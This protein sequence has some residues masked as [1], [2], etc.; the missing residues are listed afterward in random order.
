MSAEEEGY[1]DVADD[2]GASQQQHLQEGEQ[3]TA[4]ALAALAAVQRP[5]KQFVERAPP[6]RSASVTKSQ[7]LFAEIRAQME[8]GPG[9]SLEACKKAVHLGKSLLKR[10]RL[11]EAE[12]A[13]CIAEETRVALLEGDN[14]STAE[15]FTY[16]GLLREA[17]GRFDEALAKY[18]A[19]HIMLAAALGSTHISTISAGLRSSQIKSHKNE[20]VRPAPAPGVCLCAR[21]PAPMC[22]RTGPCLRPRPAG[23]EQRLLPAHVRDLRAQVS[24]LPQRLTVPHALCPCFCCTPRTTRTNADTSDKGSGCTMRP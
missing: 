23:E 4:D 11:Q 16:M 20:C 18:E 21:V 17:Q 2:D 22:T 5:T 1:I 8:Q 10:G 15:A 3:D 13:F 6:Q 19:A 14:E 12:R 7:R 24:R 9:P